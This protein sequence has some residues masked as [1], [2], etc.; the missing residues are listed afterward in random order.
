VIVRGEL[1]IGRHRMVVFD[2]DTVDVAWHGGA[3]SAF[4]VCWA[5]VPF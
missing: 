5:V 1:A 3:T 4:G 2:V